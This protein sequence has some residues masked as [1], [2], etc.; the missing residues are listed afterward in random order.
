MW[1]RCDSKS[2]PYLNA[3]QSICMNTLARV[4]FVLLSLL[5]YYIYTNGY[6]FVPGPITDIIYTSS[7]FVCRTLS[8]LLAVFTLP[9]HV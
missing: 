3:E 2:L 9:I 6:V 1:L 7:A 8:S 5:S 4:W